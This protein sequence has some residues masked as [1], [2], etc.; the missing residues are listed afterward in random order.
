[1]ASN[2]LW[3]SAPNFFTAIETTGMIA[4]D[5]SVSSTLMASMNPS[6]AIVITTVSTGYMTPGPRT[7]R[8]AAMSLVARDMRS[9]V[10]QR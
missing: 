1:M 3:I 7:I 4:S 6:A 9:T 5:T 2:R 10:R 8:T